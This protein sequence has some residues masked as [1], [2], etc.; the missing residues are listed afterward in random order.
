M[1]RLYLK[2]RCILVMGL[3]FILCHLSFSVSAFGASGPSWVKKA[4]KSVVTVKTFGD[5]GTLIGSSTGVFVTETGDVVSSYTLFRGASRAVVIDAA[6]KE[7]PV[8]CILG[9]NETYDVVKF[10]V[11]GGLKKAQALAVNPA[12]QTVGA[13]LWLLPYHE[14]KSVPQL[15]VAKSE[16]FADG[17]GYYTLSAQHSS[18]SAQQVGTPLLDE[19]GQLVAL[20]QQPGT[21]SDT[22]LYAVS[23]LFADSLHTTGL[24]INDPVLKAINIRKAL[25]ADESQAQLTLYV[26]GSVLDSA[27]YAQL[28]DDYIVQFP[29]SQE[30]YLNRAQLAAAGQHYAEADRDLEQAL[31]TASKPD[32]VH[33]LWSRL[34]YQKALY[35]PTAD[36]EPWTLQRALQEAEQAYSL[37]PLPIYRQ[38]QAYVLFADKQYAAAYERYEGLFPSALRSPELFYEASR[39]KV[40]AGDTVAQL[41]LLDSCV[42]LLSRPYLK[43]AAPYLLARAQARMDAGQHRQAVND[44]NEYGELMKSQ[45]S[46]GFYF[47]RYQAELGGRLFQQALNDINQAITMNPRSELYLAELASLQVRVGLYDDAVSTAQSLIT[48]APDHSDGYLFLGVALCLKGQKTAGLGHLQ[49]ARELGDPQADELISKYAQ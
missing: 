36:Y 40:M 45:L 23:A 39:C 3:L 9:A 16:T 18:L 15:Q 21:D 12:V 29:Q 41:A 42:A 11:G 20:L 27:A 6:G 49:R 26:A 48:L 28:V 24:S 2:V 14:Q 4:A 8:D 19:A 31:K 43:E 10:R 25:P 33:Y 13:A 37:N 5:D 47:L 46:D 7:W 38:Q 44:L 32:E 35:M 30:G 17:Y 22:L 34:V 1:N